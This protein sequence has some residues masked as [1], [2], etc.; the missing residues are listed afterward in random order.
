MFISRLLADTK[1]FRSVGLTSR[2][3]RDACIALGCLFIGCGLGGVVRAETQ[4][5][6]DPGQPGWERAPAQ[7]LVH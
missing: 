5:G 3:P 4:T 7:A 2:F 6:D 1:G